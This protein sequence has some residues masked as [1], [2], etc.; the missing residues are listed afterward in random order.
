MLQSE[1]AKQQKSEN[2]EKSS[3]VGL[4]LGFS[5]NILNWRFLDKMSQYVN[6]QFSI[7]PMPQ[8]I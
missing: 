5:F 8:K 1:E 4:T 3:L 2:K 7:K 6:F